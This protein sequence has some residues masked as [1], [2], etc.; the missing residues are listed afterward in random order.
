MKV[1][2]LMARDV[3]S[4][5]PTDPVT[6]AAQIM[7]EQDC[8]CVPVVDPGKSVLGMITDRDTCMAAYTRGQAL[9][10]MTVAEV[11][12]DGP[13]VCRTT[14]DVETALRTMAEKQ[15]H[16]LPVVDENQRLAGMLSLADVVQAAD[17]KDPAARREYAEKIV[18]AMTAVTRP[19]QRREAQTRARREALAAGA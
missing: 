2:K 4:C 14:D 16:R 11:M 18:E 1:S 12:S 8:G 13:S 15:L 10:V 17:S 19:R 9:G 6:R 7:W 3:V 5:S